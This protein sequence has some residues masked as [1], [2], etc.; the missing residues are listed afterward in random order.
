VL[1]QVADLIRS[2]STQPIMVEGH[3]DP[4]PI[5]GSVFPT[6]WELSTARAS[7]VV[8]SL[9]AGGVPA[10]RLSAAGYAALH[11]ISTNA[12]PD[13]RSRNRRVEIVLL[14]SGRGGSTR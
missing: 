7:R 10:A 4:V 8:R 11:P 6:N 12:T 9:I 3:T 2:K 5:H 1:T 13:G 14:R